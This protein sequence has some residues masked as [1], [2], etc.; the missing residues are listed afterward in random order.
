MHRRLRALNATL[1]T[2]GLPE[3]A[4]GV[5]VH[6]GSLVCGAIGS[7]ERL[8]YTVIGDTVNVAAR[9]ESLTRAYDACHVL[10]SQATVDAVGSAMEFHEIDRVSVKGRETRLTVFSPSREPA[11]SELS[12]DPEPDMVIPIV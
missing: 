12:N 4:I 5:G 1:R 9:L 7:P 8:E 3:L 10:C 2:R 6:T 11:V